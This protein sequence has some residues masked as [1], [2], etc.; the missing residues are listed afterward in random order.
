M[1]EN[2]EELSENEVIHDQVRVTFTTDIE[3]YKVEEV[4]MAVPASLDSLG[5]SKVINHLCQIEENSAVEFIFEHQDSNTIISS[6]L[7]SF[8]RSKFLSLETELALKYYPKTPRPQGNKSVFEGRSWYS[9]LA[10]AQ[11]YTIVSGS[12][13]GRIEAFSLDENDNLSKHNSFLPT[14]HQSNII[15]GKPSPIKSM[16]MFNHSSSDF[17]LLAA[18]LKS[19]LVSLLG[20]PDTNP[21]EEKPVRLGC[22]SGHKSSVESIDLFSNEK[23]IFLCSGS[24]DKNIGIFR[25]DAAE[26]KAKTNLEREK[27]NS[28]KVGNKR[29]EVEQGEILPIHPELV[30]SGH[31]DKVS[32][33]QVRNKT[34]YSAGLDVAIK[35]W[36]INQGLDCK[37]TLNAKRAVTSLDVSAHAEILASSHSD[38]IIRFWDPREDVQ[39]VFSSERRVPSKSWVSDVNW[40]SDN[41]NLLVSCDYSGQVVLWDIRSVKPLEVINECHGSKALAVGFEPSGKFIISAGADSTIRAH[42]W[43]SV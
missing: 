23:N 37:Q 6:S 30:L 21:T 13:N 35:V 9:C 19:G 38:G 24:W 12:Y 26:L 18:G 42:K 36:D 11:N 28:L 40:H 32:S 8:L 17:S 34:L 7:E 15:L 39:S 29:K 22:L 16:K 2:N 31:R 25:L 27:E 41:T 33:V 5:L 14:F 4:S 1:V 3:K 10:F 20:Y 43:Q